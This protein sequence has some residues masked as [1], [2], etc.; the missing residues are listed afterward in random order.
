MAYIFLLFASLI[1]FSALAYDEVPPTLAEWQRAA[2]NPLSPN[3]S[4]PLEYKFHGGATAGDVHVGSFAPIMPIKF[5][6]WNII[7]QLT[8]NFMGTPGDITGIRGIPQPYTG[9]GHGGSDGDAA[10]L[11]DTFFTSYI[12]PVIND[13]FSLGLGATFVFPT[14]EPSRELGSGKISMGPAVMLVYQTPESWT[15]SLQAQQIWS[16][17]GS[18]GRDKVSQM[19]VNP[20]I[21]YNLPDGW[22]LLSDMEVIA[23]WELSSNQ[24]WTV[25]IGAGVGKV[26]ALGKN[27]I[28]TRIEGYYNVVTPGYNSS[29]GFSG[30]SW[31]IGASFSFI[32][33]EL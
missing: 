24:R 29:N 1:S 8:L 22:Y 5:D 19:I 20:T 25:P 21:N 15:L 32:F 3:F 11:A 14:D 10:G 31:S 12:S 18:N 30:P 33:G 26:F 6:G 27:A 28:D 9:D 17:I 23:N 2:Q 4:L 13:E 16:V 7:N